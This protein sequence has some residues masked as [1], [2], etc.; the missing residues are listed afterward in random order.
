MSIRCHIGNG[1]RLTASGLYH[2][3]RLYL[4]SHTFAVDCFVF[5]LGG[6]DMILGISWLATLGTVQ[7]NLQQ[8]TMDFTID[9][10]QICLRGNSAFARHAVRANR[11]HVVEDIEQSWLL[12]QVEATE[13]GSL[14]STVLPLPADLESL[15][16]E[17]S[18]LFVL[19]VGLPPHW[20]VD[21]QIPM[22]P[23]TTPISVRP[24]RYNHA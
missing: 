21:H 5:P 24:Y 20:N 10:K 16:I 23:D 2:G 3:V 14:H 4:Q 19:S 6:E 1:Q 8:M 13:L 17:F 12:L 15:L 7:A 9:H 11:L 18:D 22:L